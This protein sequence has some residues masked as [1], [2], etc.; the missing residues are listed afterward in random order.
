[1]IQ[2][3][4]SEILNHLNGNKKNNT[5]KK[6]NIK[7]DFNKAYPTATNIH[8]GV[9]NKQWGFSFVLK[10]RESFIS[11]DDIQ[12]PTRDKNI[13]SENEFVKIKHFDMLEDEYKYLFLN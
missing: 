9:E 10:G 11:L 2:D 13:I 7:P 8:L 5:M 3:G 12:N 6:S 1:M 4:H